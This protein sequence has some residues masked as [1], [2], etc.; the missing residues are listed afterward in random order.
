M[1][2]IEKATKW[3]KIIRIF[4][5]NFSNFNKK[6]KKNFKLKIINL[7]V[8]TDDKNFLYPEKIRVQEILMNKFMGIN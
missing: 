4:A 1:I 8:E 2:S 5:K 6:Y 7:T 3:S